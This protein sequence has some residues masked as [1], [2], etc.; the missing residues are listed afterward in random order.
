MKDFRKNSSELD[1]IFGEMWKLDN[2]EYYIDK[3]YSE[4]ENKYFNYFEIEKIFYREER[5]DKDILIRKEKWIE[6]YIQNNYQDNE[7]IANIF[8]VINSSFPSKKK[9]YM[10]QFL[11]LNKSIEDFKKIPLFSTFSSWSGSEVPIIEKKIKFLEEINENINGLDYIEHMDYINS[12]IGALKKYI[13]DIKIRE[14]LEDYLQNK[15]CEK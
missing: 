7:K 11:K 2:Y 6:K 4:I 14:Y 3:A 8:D 9:E 12:R 13:T 10:L 15:K 1:S 5:E